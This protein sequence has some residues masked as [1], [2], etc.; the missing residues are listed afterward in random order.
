M[1]CTA[2]FSTKGS[3]DCGC[4]HAI[5]TGWTAFCGAPCYC[6]A[7]RT[8]CA[9][10]LCS[11]AKGHQQADSS[12]D[13]EEGAMQWVRPIRARSCWS[14]PALSKQCCVSSWTLQ[15]IEVWACIH[16]RPSQPHTC[17]LNPWLINKAFQPAHCI[18]QL[19]AISCTKAS[20][21]LNF[22]SLLLPIMAAPERCASIR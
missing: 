9:P 18:H 1:L 14:S 8:V 2:P 5:P 10:Y 4:C 16:M 11:R 15:H 6:L 20:K 22:L 21:P 17:R 7:T 12:N 19:H 3:A 13:L